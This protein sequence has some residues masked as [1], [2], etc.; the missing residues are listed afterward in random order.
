MT[1][2]D[3]NSSLPWFAVY[4]KS[5][6]EKHVDVTL[7]QKGYESFLPMYVKSH[8]NSKTYELPLFP[9]YVFSR[10]DTSRKLP[11][12]ST[13]GVFSIV[14]NGGVPAPIPDTEIDTI[15]SVL[16]SG[17]VPGPWPYLSQGQEVCLM[18]GPL[19][20]V[21]GFVANTNGHKWLVVS[22]HLLQRSVAVKIDRTSLAPGDISG[23]TK[24]T[25]VLT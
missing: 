22:I 16:V 23:N 15:R 8:P 5:R 6:H 3:L 11:I 25:L 18:S 10:L 14:G 9:N 4:V 20:G 7:A 2:S 24:S 12:L 17:F 1:M 21:H 13:P 19:R